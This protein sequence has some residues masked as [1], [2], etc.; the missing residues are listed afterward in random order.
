MANRKHRFWCQSCG[1]E[2]V[3]EELLFG[4]SCPSCESGKMDDWPP[5]AEGPVT[6]LADEEGLDY[7]NRFIAGDR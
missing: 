1:H 2:V 5:D 6:D 7:F 3:S 4:Q